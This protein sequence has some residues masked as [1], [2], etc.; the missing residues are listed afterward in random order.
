MCWFIQKNTTTFI[1]E[2]PSFVA[3]IVDVAHIQFAEFR[4]VAHHSCAKSYVLH[5]IQMR[6]NIVHSKNV[7]GSLFHGGDCKYGCKVVEDSHKSKNH[8]CY[9]SAVL[10]LRSFIRAIACSFTRLR[11]HRCRPSFHSDSNIALHGLRHWHFHCLGMHAL[12]RQWH[13]NPFRL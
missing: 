4:L 3:F 2:S 13:T 10:L 11:R 5:G 6:S 1:T 8:C 12:H 7:A 9:G